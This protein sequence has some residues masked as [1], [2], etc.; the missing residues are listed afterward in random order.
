MQ[1]IVGIRLG[2]PH[3]S[4]GITGDDDAFV[5]SDAE[6]LV[7]RNLVA[8]LIFNKEEFPVVKVSAV[9]QNGL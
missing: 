8:E 4:E 6:D 7:V 5:R 3:I 1:D 2:R 9:E